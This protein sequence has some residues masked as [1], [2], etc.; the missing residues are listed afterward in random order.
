[1]VTHNKKIVKQKKTNIMLSKE[2]VK[3]SSNINNQYTNMLNI[4]HVFVKIENR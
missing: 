4:K 2:K 3:M 1:M